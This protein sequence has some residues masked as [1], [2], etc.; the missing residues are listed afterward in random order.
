MPYMLPT[1]PVTAQSQ[2]KEDEEAFLTM[3]A[4]RKINALNVEGRVQ[5][6]AHIVNLNADSLSS[7]S[8]RSFSRRFCGDTTSDPRQGKR[9]RRYYQDS[10]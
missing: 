6:I 10:Y 9:S 8:A 4:D 2:V 1:S 5:S 3:K 7:Q